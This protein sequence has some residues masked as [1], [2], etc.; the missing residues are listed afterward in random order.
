MHDLTPP[1]LSQSLS[2]GLRL[3]SPLPPPA[4]RCPHPTC[5]LASL[6]SHLTAIPLAPALRPFPCPSF[7]CQPCP[8]PTLIPPPLCY[9]LRSRLPSS[10]CSCPTK[11]CPVIGGCLPSG[12][13]RPAL[14]SPP[15]PAPSTSIS[16]ALP[17][18]CPFRR[19]CPASVNNP[20]SHCCHLLSSSLLLTSPVL[21]LLR[22]LSTD[23][24]L[25]FIP[26]TLSLFLI[27]HERS[28]SGEHRSRQGAVKRPA[29]KDLSGKSPKRAKTER[30]VHAH[31]GSVADYRRF[32]LAM[33][34][35]RRIGD[36]L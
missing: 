11:M 10:A 26:F 30:C 18:L 9:C 27:Q 16:P 7:P 1:S 17:P 19:P 20:A 6:H 2:Q 14:P 5:L 15:P 8:W 34:L 12:P 13:Y 4:P 21:C 31:I 28:T 25:L 29:Q 3:P 35:L 32:L 24:P 23:S 33:R 36:W 22:L